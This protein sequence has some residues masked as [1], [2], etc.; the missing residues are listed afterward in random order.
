MNRE[1]LLSWMALEGWDPIETEYHWCLRKREGRRF[2][3][4]NKERYLPSG[5]QQYDINSPVD[6]S[7]RYIDPPE[8]LLA[9][10]AIRVLG[11]TYDT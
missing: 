2:M 3:C 6:L 10:F 8:Q 7:E 11:V 9:A 4:I 5:L 1:Q